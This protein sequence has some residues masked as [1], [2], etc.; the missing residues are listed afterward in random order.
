MG[1]QRCKADLSLL[2]SWFV[3]RDTGYTVVHAGHF[4]G[5]CL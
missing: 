2:N 5:E 4:L 3:G 1:E